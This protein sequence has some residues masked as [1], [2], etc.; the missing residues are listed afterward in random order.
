MEQIENK[1]QEGRCKS[2]TSI[3]TLNTYGL[4]QLKIKRLSVWLKKQDNCMLSIK[5]NCLQG[6]LNKDSEKSKAIE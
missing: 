4:N 1:Q 3:I 5:K 6:S 2:T